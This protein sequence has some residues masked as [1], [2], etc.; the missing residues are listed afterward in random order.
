[1][2]GLTLGPDWPDRDF[3]CTAYDVDSGAFVAWDAASGAPFDRAVTS[4]CAVPAH[5]PA[6]HHRRPPLHGRGR[7]LGHRTP[8]WRKATTRW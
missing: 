1:M 2:V 5:L 7:H 8:A 4:S 6:D 3:A